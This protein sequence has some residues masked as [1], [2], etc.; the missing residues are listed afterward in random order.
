[1]QLLS[2]RMKFVGRF[3]SQTSTVHSLTQSTWKHAISAFQQH[4][5]NNTKCFSLTH[6]H[7]H[8]RPLIFL[9]LTHRHHQRW[10]QFKGKFKMSTF[11]RSAT[12]NKYHFLCKLQNT[13]MF[14]HTNWLRLIQFTPHVWS[15]P[16]ASSCLC[17]DSWGRELGSGRHWQMSSLNPTK[18]ERGREREK[19]DS[20]FT[21]K[22]ICTVA[23][24]EALIQMTSFSSL[25]SFFIAAL[26]SQACQVQIT[27][28][29]TVRNNDSSSESDMNSPWWWGLGSGQP[30]SCPSGNS[31]HDGLPLVW[32][33]RSQC[34]QT[35]RAPLAQS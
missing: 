11:L 34:S 6:K 9:P 30:A 3:L 33:W 1:M 2:V 27:P 22:A 5:I 13:G 10:K 4:A 35:C 28:S 24:L 19:H 17:S 23:T 26:N 32:W 21:D 29:C 16:K 20:F 25:H 7:A 8:N 31:H 18:W 14:I 12:C 15:L